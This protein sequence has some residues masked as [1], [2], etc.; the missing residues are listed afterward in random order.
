[1]QLL[2]TADVINQVCNE[3]AGLGVLSS[4]QRCALL[5][6]AAPA[7]GARAARLSCASS[8]LVSGG[9]GEDLSVEHAAHNPVYV[10]MSNM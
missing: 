4:S 8:L 10:Y 3:E 6:P 5:F 9:A 2:I 1:M 7:G